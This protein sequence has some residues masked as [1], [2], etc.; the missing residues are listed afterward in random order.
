MTHHTV[1]IVQYPPAVLDLRASVMRAV[2]HVTEAADAG[3]ASLCFQ[4]HG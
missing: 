3:R 4:R 1:A 2:A